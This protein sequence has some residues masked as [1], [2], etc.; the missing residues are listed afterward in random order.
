MYR[1]F[2]KGYDGLKD[3]KKLRELFPRH[4]FLT[5][6]LKGESGVYVVD[7]AIDRPDY[8]EWSESLWGYP[9][10]LPTVYTGD[11]SEYNRGIIPVK[12][13]SGLTIKI[14][15]SFV[16][17]K[18]FDVFTGEI[19]GYEY[20]R[21][22]EYGRVAF[23]LNEKLLLEGELSPTHPL[24]FKFTKQILIHSYW[25]VPEMIKRFLKLEPEDIV[26]IVRAGLGED[27]NFLEDADQSSGANK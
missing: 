22:T 20:D 23:E 14:F 4:Q 13:K 15:P 6:Q 7:N 18:N 12:L 26:P 1:L 19:G 8:G 9:V 25:C 10:C 5:G 17:M 11:L 16:K 21:D 3:L 27:A 2:A 24:A